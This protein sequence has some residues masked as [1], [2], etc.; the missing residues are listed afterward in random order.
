MKGNAQVLKRLNLA[1]KGELT[2]INQYFLHAR[3]LEDWGVTKLG[4]HEFKESIEE[5]HHADLL[6]KRILLLEGLPNL[7]DLGKL[8]IGENTEEII[9]NDLKLELEGIANYR[10]GIKD[11]EAAHDYVTRDLFIQIL[12]DEE[13]HEDHLNT[14]LKLI[15]TIGIEK[16]IQLNADSF[17]QQPE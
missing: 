3:M 4:K 2:A 5:M 8:Y 15:E 11:C 17:D 10:E 13:G 12:K 14:Q 6:I 7:Q 16:Y 1:L 9:K